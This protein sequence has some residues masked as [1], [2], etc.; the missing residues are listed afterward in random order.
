MENNNPKGS[1]GTPFDTFDTTHSPVEYANN[2]DNF[3]QGQPQDPFAARP[4]VASYPLPLAPR[5]FVIQ[6]DLN[7]T[8][9]IPASVY[10]RSGEL[11]NDAFGHVGYSSD[12]YQQDGYVSAFSLQYILCIGH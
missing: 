10:Q 4:T 5:E 9:P 3:Q 6:S 8:Q 11:W 12:M 1:N 7:V 2:I